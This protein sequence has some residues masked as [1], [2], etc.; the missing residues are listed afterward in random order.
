MRFR[1]CADSAETLW[2]LTLPLCRACPV[3]CP[4]YLLGLVELL[5]DLALCNKYHGQ[6]CGIEVWACQAVG[7]SLCRAMGAEKDSMLNGLATDP[8]TLT[9]WVLVQQQKEVMP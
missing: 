8:L 1:D 7:Q 2:F 6:Y 9:Q 3:F 5:C 4:R